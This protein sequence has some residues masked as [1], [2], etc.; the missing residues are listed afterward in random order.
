MRVVRPFTVVPYLPESIRSLRDI[1]YNLWWTW[2]QDAREL[3]V[4]IDPDLWTSCGHNPV[5]M[6]GRVSQ[7]RLLEVSRDDGFLAHLERVRDTLEAYLSA[8]TWYDQLIGDA[9]RHTIAY[10]SAEFGLHECLPIYS[11]G[12]GLLAGDHL[13]S[14]SGLG[15]PLVGVGLAY[16]NGYCRQYLNAD[17]WQQEFLH[18]NDFYSLP[19]T[20]ERDAQG[21]P[22]LVSIQVPKPD[23]D[24]WF[25]IW[26][27]RVGRV[28]LF[29]LD[30]KI[31]CNRPEDRS[32]SDQLYGGDYEHRFVQE[33]ALGVGG[34]RALKALGIQPDVCHM[35]EGHSAFLAVERIRELVEQLGLSFEQAREAVIPGNVFTTHTP[36]PAGIDRFG[37]DLID[38]YF[39]SWFKK[40]GLDRKAFLA[41]GRQNP[42]DEQ[43]PFSMAI[44]ALKTAGYSNGVSKLHGEVSRRMF[45]GIWPEVP[46]HETPIDHV[47]NGCHVRSYVSDPLNEL[48]IRYAGMRWTYEAAEADANWR[49]PDLLP[50]AELWRVHE[51][52]RANLVT[53]GRQ[54]VKKQLKRRGASPR[55]V[56]GADEIL[57][58]EALTIGFAR[59]FATYKRATLLFQDPERLSSL[60][61]QKDRPVQILYA[62]KAHPKDEAGKA[63]IQQIVKYARDERFRKHI[64]FL[65]DYDI[66]TARYLVQGVDVWL[67]TPRRP[68]EASGTSGMKAAANGVLNCSILDGWWC[69]GYDGINGWAIGSGED[70]EDAQY[71]DN[72]ESRALY[73]LL[74]KHVVP[75]FYQR[76]RDELP[77]EWIKRMKRALQTCIP[78]FST[79][80]ML[81]DY[82]Q[83]A[84]V[85]AGRRAAV[86]NQDG[87]AAARELWDWKMGLFQKW[88]QIRI[89]RID[90]PA[91]GEIQVGRNLEV[92]AKV[93]LGPIRPESVDVQVF[94]GLLDEQGR[95]SAGTALGMARDAHAALPE[96]FHLFRVQI[97]CGASGRFGFAVRV[98]PRHSNLST[99][100]V[101][102][103]ITWA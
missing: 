87:C 86:M 26:R 78:M 17:G 33:L 64:V 6:L 9:P 65:E 88:A 43:E 21:Q 84:Y 71:Q 61:N 36:V 52:C 24:V 37:A 42:H 49:G 73:D 32:I 7:E 55:E 40:L 97:P 59:R 23:R 102:G 4:R 81:R 74:E 10:F 92:T 58:P 77:R 70:Y 90:T 38:K 53:W 1:A 95:I 75:L 48:F 67:N 82:A 13:K 44:L 30:S 66:T 83:K 34:L 18:G 22:L 93:H 2:N 91:D 39:G 72:V 20:L 101:P 3:F 100:F 56:E 99:T 12:L 54:R 14:A 68:H 47:T 76:G 60:L 41:L 16:Y 15:L 46:E 27:V 98:L 45:R 5:A 79:H 28:S 29:L 94:S 96:G 31:D 25:Q 8:K 35:N 11:G 89:E 50:D 80:R 57:D 69:E 62:G 85:P 103:L 19:S 51:R 63:F